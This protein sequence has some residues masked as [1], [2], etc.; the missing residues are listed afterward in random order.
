MLAL[1]LAG[2]PLA[3]AQTD[4][5]LPHP[6]LSTHNFFFPFLIHTS[7]PKKHSLKMGLGTD[8]EGL[9][10]HKNDSLEGS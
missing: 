5:S 4:S 7:P 9:T 10:L 8:R 2:R 3:K 1:L 6:V